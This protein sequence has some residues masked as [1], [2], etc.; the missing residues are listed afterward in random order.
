[1]ISWAFPVEFS[2]LFM[3][4]S[5]GKRRQDS[6]ELP[7]TTAVQ[8]E[9]QTQVAAGEQRIPNWFIYFGDFWD[10]YTIAI[11]EISSTM[12]SHYNDITR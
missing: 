5:A 4:F 9:L 6:G 11:P 3:S 1:M 8:P 7:R 2:W 10:S 12:V